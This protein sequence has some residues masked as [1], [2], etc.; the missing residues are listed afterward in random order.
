MPPF[1]RSK[2]ALPALW[3]HLLAPDRAQ[4]YGEE[5]PADAVQADCPDNISVRAKKRFDVAT[6]K[7]EWVTVTT[8]TDWTPRDL[9]LGD[10]VR[11]RWARDG[12]PRA[13]FGG[14]RELHEAKRGRSARWAAELKSSLA[15]PNPQDAEAGPDPLGLNV[16]RPSVVVRGL[17]ASLDKVEKELAAMKEMLASMERLLKQS[18][19][20]GARGWGGG[21]SS[22]N[23]GGGSGDLDS[24]AAGE[25]MEAVEG[26][27]MSG[28]AP[29]GGALAASGASGDA[30]AKDK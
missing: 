2:T 15:P 25:P 7:T 30:A 1:V 22:S 5:E 13:A 20:G 27:P 24:A 9:R 12:G 23:D 17:E 19:P 3:L 21:A 6:K 11:A 28:T 8:K 14:G 10:W 18:A 16:Q 26:V 4:V 29:P